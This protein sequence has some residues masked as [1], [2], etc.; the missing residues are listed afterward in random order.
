MVRQAK[1]GFIQQL[2][3][4]IAE[5]KDVCASLELVD[6]TDL[7][8]VLISRSGDLPSPKTLASMMERDGYEPLGK[9]RIGDKMHVVWTKQPDHF[10]SLGPSGLSVDPSKVRAYLEER[11]ARLD[12]E[13]EL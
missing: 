4:M 8:D 12:L 9:V 6:V 3:D 11:K 2:D 5:D 10:R 7:S 13:D 1:P